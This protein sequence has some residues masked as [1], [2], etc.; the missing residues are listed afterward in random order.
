MSVAALV[1]EDGGSEDEAIAALLHDALEDCADQVS[2]VK[3][4]EEFGRT[5]RRLVVACTDTPADFTG[6]KKSPWKLRKLDYINHIRNGGA[7]RVSLADKVHNARSILRDHQIEGE[8]VWER[9]AASRDE[10]LWYY[11]E[12]VSAY[13]Q[14]G[15]E[16]FLL[17]ELHS[18]VVRLY[19]RVSTQC[20]TE[21]TEEGEADSAR[22][23]TTP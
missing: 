8:A 6:G 1:L 3:L 18:I 2:A 4:E 16:G 7:S 12:L 23:S 15:H 21:T 10:T 20:A 14:A 19:D 22:S 13:R 17:E 5:V 9:F 11:R